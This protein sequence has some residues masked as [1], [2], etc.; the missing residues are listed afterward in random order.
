MADKK[1]YYYLKLKEGFF[2]SDDMKILQ[3]SNADGYLYSDILLKLY[4][5]SL[6]T[7]GRLMFRESIPYTPEMISTVTNHQ[8]GTVEKA[9]KIFL[10]MGF[11]EILD[12]GAIY[13][14]DIQNYI[15]KSSNEADRKRE[16]RARIDAEKSTLAIE[17]NIATG[18]M[19]GQMSEQCPPEIRDR[20]R[21]RVRDRDRDKDKDRDNDGSN[22][23]S[24]SDIS[25]IITEWN[26]IPD[27]HQIKKISPSSTRGK[28]L[29]QLIAEFD[30]NDIF[31]A[32][33]NITKST[34]LLKGNSKW[35][36]TFDWFIKLDNFTKVLENQYADYK[37]GTSKSTK[38][39]STQEY[40]NATAGW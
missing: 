3:K 23:I 8:I 11:I 40:L 6:R 28:A 21:D 26:S 29:A 33:N 39:M 22:N 5:K 18:Q 4:L 7:E 17:D 30:L 12:N 37:S 10:Q 35:H 16:Y 20:V 25:S 38:N 24:P 1:E 2:D 31:Q 14:S 32:I 36:L 27:I 9:L 13:V 15:G 34:F 19:S